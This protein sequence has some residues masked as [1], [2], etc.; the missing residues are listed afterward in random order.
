M[1]ATES[2]MRNRRN[3]LER[4]LL[5]RDADRCV[6]I[7]VVDQR[8]EGLVGGLPEYYCWRGSE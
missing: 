7:R 5:V 8:V 3:A 1:E 6:A 4:Y 2:N